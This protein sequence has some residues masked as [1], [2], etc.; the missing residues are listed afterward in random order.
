MPRYNYACLDCQKKVIEEHPD[1]VHYPRDE[2][3]LQPDV[4]EQL[5]LFETSHGMNPTEEELAEAVVCPRCQSTNCERTLH[6]CEFHSYTLGYG[7][8]DKAGAK[9]DM[10]IYTLKND[11]PYKEHRVE[12]EAEEIESRIKKSAKPKPKH[13]VTSSPD[14]KNNK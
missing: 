6:G 4:Y 8:C 1:K 2:P 5:V 13:F 14:K 11:D 7:Y 3:E 9:R 12:G 10:D